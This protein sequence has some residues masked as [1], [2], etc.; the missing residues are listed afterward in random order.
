MTFAAITPCFTATR[1]YC[2]HD[3][4]AMICHLR[5]YYTIV[6]FRYCYAAD[7]RLLPVYFDATCFAMPRRLQMAFSPCCFLPRHVYVAIFRHAYSHAAPFT[8]ARSAQCYATQD[9]ERAD[10]AV[11]RHAT[12]M[13]SARHADARAAIYFRYVVAPSRRHAD[14][15]F[16][17]YACRRHAF[18]PAYAFVAAHADDAAAADV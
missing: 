13:S 17:L 1:H 6:L 16:L 7:Y 15:R 14:C 8:Y 10:A 11:C 3:M 9:G 2:R 18:A 5:R 4:A 12:L